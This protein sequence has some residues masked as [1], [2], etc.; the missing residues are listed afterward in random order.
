MQNIGK[1]NLEKVNNMEAMLNNCGMK[2]AT[3]DTILKGWAAG[4]KTPN[5]LKLG[6]SGLVYSAGG[7]DAHDALTG[8]KS[9]TIEGDSYNASGN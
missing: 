6:A 7:K 3:Y 5:G 2:S 8:T 1:W 9:W 4:S